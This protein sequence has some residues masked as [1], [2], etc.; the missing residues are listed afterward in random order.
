MIMANSSNKTK[1]L[2]GADSQTSFFKDGESKARSS[3]ALHS[4]EGRSQMN[5]YKRS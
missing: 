5:F 3:S 4:Q 1:L 2:G